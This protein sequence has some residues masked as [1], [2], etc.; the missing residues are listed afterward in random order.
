[1]PPGEAM[2]STTNNSFGIGHSGGTGV[3]DGVC[4]GKGI[5]TRGKTVEVA[6]IVE[7]IQ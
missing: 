7:S 6:V 1:M 2:S 5:T 4:A 3:L